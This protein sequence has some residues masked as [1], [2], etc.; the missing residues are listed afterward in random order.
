[1]ALIDA[2]PESLCLLLCQVDFCFELQ[3][4]K[5]LSPLKIALLLKAFGFRKYMGKKGCW[6]VEPFTHWETKSQI[7]N[8]LS[9]FL[10]THPDL[11]RFLQQLVRLANQ[12][13]LVI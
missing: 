1:L 9:A 6:Q 5:N 2:P 12:Q 13:L 4:C 10:D 11:V 3:G 8:D 7:G